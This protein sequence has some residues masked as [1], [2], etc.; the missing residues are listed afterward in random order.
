M[1]LLLIQGLLPL[2]TVWLTKVLVDSLVAAVEAG[3]GWEIV[4]TPLLLAVAMAV[5][6]L[7]GHVLRAV[8]RWLRTAQGELVQD[9]IAGLIQER[10]V[11]AD[12]V[13][14]DSPD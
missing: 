11:A 14:Y 4:R 8:T 10:A 13:L 7:V 5:L 12:L 1:A 3:G 2:A 6:F 9:H